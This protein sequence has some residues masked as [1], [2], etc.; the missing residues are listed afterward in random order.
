MAPQDEIL[1]PGLEQL[2][3]ITQVPGGVLPELVDSLRTLPRMPAIFVELPSDAPHRQPAGAIGKEFPVSGHPN[4][5][6][7]LQSGNRRG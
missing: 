3:R 4:I 5:I 7:R 6:P 1:R 2:R